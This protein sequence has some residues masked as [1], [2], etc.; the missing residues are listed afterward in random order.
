MVTFI[1]SIK[2]NFIQFN[3]MTN[4]KTLL[5]ESIDIAEAEISVITDNRPI[6]YITELENIKVMAWHKCIASNNL[7]IDTLTGLVHPSPLDMQKVSA[8]SHSGHYYWCKCYASLKNKNICNRVKIVFNELEYLSTNPNYFPK[9]I[10]F[11]TRY[12]VDLLNYITEI[13]KLKD[14]YYHNEFTIRLDEYKKMAIMQ[15]EFDERNFQTQLK[16]YNGIFTHAVVRQHRQE[17]IA[18]KEKYAKIIKDATEAVYSERNRITEKI[19]I[20]EKE[21]KE[22]LEKLKNMKHL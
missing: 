18:N 21:R 15:E 20:I 10:L 14:V 11:N 1:Y 5:E 2:T 16:G 6:W 8:L 19:D 17:F 9:N 12:F 3:S 4:L 13:E 22:Y 7:L